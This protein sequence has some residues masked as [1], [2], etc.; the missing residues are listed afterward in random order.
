MSRM[1]KRF[2]HVFWSILVSLILVSLTIA[3]LI[4]CRNT[5]PEENTQRRLDA[6]S[7]LSK[8]EVSDILNIQFA[9]P[10]RQVRK[11]DRGKTV[12]SSCTYVPTDGMSFA[13]L[14]L[15]VTAR[16][17]GGDPDRVIEEH[18]QSLRQAMGNTSF[19]PASVDGVGEAAVHLPGLGQFVVFDK[20]RLLVLTLRRQSKESTQDVLTQLAKASLSE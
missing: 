17:N 7:L 5:V 15:L 14:N 9:A 2:A 11:D 3:P 12:M 16:P 8:E 10:N 4:G 18:V 19:S 6:C 20:S 1:R 13:S